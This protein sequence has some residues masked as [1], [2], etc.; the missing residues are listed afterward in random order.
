MNRTIRLLIFCALAFT[1]CTGFMGACG[2]MAGDFI[3]E[4]LTEANGGS[5]SDMTPEDK[6]QVEC[7]R[8]GWHWNRLPGTEPFCH[9][10]AF[11]YLNYYEAADN[12]ICREHGFIWKEVPFDMD[13]YKTTLWKCRPANT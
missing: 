2:M 10:V 1:F 9:Q 12:E 4:A 6:A 8:K 5:G 13:G 7:N 11:E 3:N